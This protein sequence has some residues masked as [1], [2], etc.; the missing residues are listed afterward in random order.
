MP[1]LLPKGEGT[2][3]VYPVDQTRKGNHGGGS[4][5]NIWEGLSAGCQKPRLVC[6]LS[7]RCVSVCLGQG[8]GEGVGRLQTWQ[9]L[10]VFLS[11]VRTLLEKYSCDVFVCLAYPV[12][13]YTPEHE[14]ILTFPW[15]E[16]LKMNHHGIYMHMKSCYLCRSYHLFSLS[17][18]LTQV[19]I[20][21]L[22]K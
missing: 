11:K 8:R 4:W 12:W 9:L 13:E 6:I 5:V 22:F 15:N 21:D 16:C 2:I 14:V 18:C 20:S 19:F 17:I 10:F 1:E 7:Q 3:L